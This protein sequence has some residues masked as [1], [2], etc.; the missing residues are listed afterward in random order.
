MLK[1]FAKCEAEGKSLETCLS[2]DPP[3]PQLSQLQDAD[4]TRLTECLGSGDL[5]S[6]KDRWSGCLADI[7]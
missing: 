1:E 7:R 2:D 3:P 4:R 5:A 6:T